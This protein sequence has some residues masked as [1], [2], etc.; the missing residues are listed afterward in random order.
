[1]DSGTVAARYGDVAA[2]STLAAR[3]VAASAPQA[4]SRILHVARAAA[5]QYLRIRDMDLEVG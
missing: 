5:G 1:M 4:R 3:A 2:A